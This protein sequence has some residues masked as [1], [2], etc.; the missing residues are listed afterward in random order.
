[1][2]RPPMRFVIDLDQEYMATGRNRLTVAEW[3]NAMPSC[4]QRSDASMNIP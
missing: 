3:R 4:A 1:M 2:L